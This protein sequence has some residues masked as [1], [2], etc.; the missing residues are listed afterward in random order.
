LRGRRVSII[1]KGAANDYILDL[2]LRRGGL[3]IR[4]VDLQVVPAPETVAA[5]ANGA[6]AAG[7]ISEPFASE[8]VARG[9]GVVLN[10]DYANDVLI[11][12][13]YFNENFAQ[14]RR[15]DGIRLLTGYYQAVRDLQPPYRDE[16]IAIIAQ[17]TRLSPETIRAAARPYHDLS[18]D[19]HLADLEAM[20]QFVMA[21]GETSYQE[22][23]DFAQYVDATL[24]TAALARLGLP[25]PQG[26]R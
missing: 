12:A 8:A 18:G 21:Q 14:A 23:L 4:D 19:L 13:M 26:G 5:L 7:M 20:Q 17:Y 2:A 11:V 25:S 22:P 3:T 16:D 15:E 9:A 1:A 24:G 6:I 10:N